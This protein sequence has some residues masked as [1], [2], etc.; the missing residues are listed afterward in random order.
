M[1]SADTRW[2][3]FTKAKY[4]PES[5][6]RL[7]SRPHRNR[8]SQIATSTHRSQGGLAIPVPATRPAHHSELVTNDESKWWS[9]SA[10][11]PSDQRGV[12]IA[13]P[14]LYRRVRHGLLLHPAGMNFSFA[15]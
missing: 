11:L 2:E 4:L 7:H 5:Q 13:D 9:P 8:E 6:G 1:Q 12:E 15:I 10:M 3:H 14:D